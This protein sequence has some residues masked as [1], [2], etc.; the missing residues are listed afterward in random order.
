MADKSE[1]IMAQ[2]MSVGVSEH[3]A[4]VIA[5]CIVTRKSCSWVNTDEV[6]DKLL[7]DLNHLIEKNDYR[8]KVV[9]DAVPTRSKYIWEVKVL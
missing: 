6:S 8:I 1:E 7:K 5:D 2:L 4:L 3:D 9:I